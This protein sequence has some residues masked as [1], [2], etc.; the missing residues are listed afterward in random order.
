LCQIKKPL[1]A[2]SPDTA[3]QDC[4]LS[5]VS[6]ICP[7]DSALQQNPQDHPYKRKKQQSFIVNYEED[8]KG[9]TGLDKS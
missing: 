1:F 8:H 3:G 5:R 7:S 6:Q 4:H 9:K 2:N